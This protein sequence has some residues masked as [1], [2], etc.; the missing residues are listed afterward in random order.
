MTETSDSV[1]IFLAAT[2]TSPFFL[3]FREK[4]SAS[5]LKVLN[6]KNQSQIRFSNFFSYPGISQLD[7][8]STWTEEAKSSLEAKKLGSIVDLWKVVAERQVKRK[9][10]SLTSGVKYRKILKISPSAY[11]RRGLLQEVFLR[12]RFGGLVYGGAYT[13]RGLFSGSS[14][15]PPELSSSRDL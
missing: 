15:L 7:L 6:R 8:L 9:F 4:Q 3:I 5:I 1:S 2:L 13:R 14:F 12:F 11:I 10:Q